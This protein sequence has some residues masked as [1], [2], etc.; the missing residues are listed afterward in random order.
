MITD[1]DAMRCTNFKVQDRLFGLVFFEENISTLLF[2]IFMYK[3]RKMFL[4]N[5]Q[6]IHNLHNKAIQGDPHLLYSY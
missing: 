1:D 2:L 5:I 6:L 4:E 3:A